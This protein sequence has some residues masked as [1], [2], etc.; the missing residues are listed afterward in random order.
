MADANEYAPTHLLRDAGDARSI[1]GVKH[2]LPVVVDRFV[3]AH[4]DG[5]AARG[6]PFPIC[7]SCEA[8]R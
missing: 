7:S 8:G 4:I 6:I 3:Q 1:C 2:P 5:R